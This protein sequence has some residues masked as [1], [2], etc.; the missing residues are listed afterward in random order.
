MKT[1]CFT[2]KGG[3]LS[4]NPI[5]T[6]FNNEHG[7][8]NITPSC[9]K[10]GNEGT[11]GSLV[12]CDDGILACEKTT[13]KSPLKQMTMAH[14]KPLDNDLNIERTT[15]IPIRATFKSSNVDEKEQRCSPT[16]IEHILGKAICKLWNVI[17]FYSLVFC[18]C[19]L[20]AILG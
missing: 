15:K 11:C 19:G 14:P 16:S 18:G 3:T 6:I 5:I 20:S 8:C 17:Y 4:N 2:I 12:A 13:F 7:P 10:L 9:P 1:L